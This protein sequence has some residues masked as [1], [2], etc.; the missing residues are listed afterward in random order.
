MNLFSL[1]AD[2]HSSSSLDS[3]KG[4]MEEEILD[5][6]LEFGEDSL[7]FVSVRSG[8]TPIGNYETKADEEDFEAQDSSSS[9]L[10][11]GSWETIENEMISNSSHRRSDNSSYVASSSRSSISIIQQVQQWHGID[12]TTLGDAMSN[13]A[14]SGNQELISLLPPK[15]IVVTT[16]P[17]QH[18]K[19][20]ALFCDCRLEPTKLSRS[21]DEDS[22]IPSS[23][24]TG[25]LLLDN[26]KQDPVSCN[27]TI[28]GKHWRLYIDNGGFD[29]YM[30]RSQQQ[31]RIEFDNGSTYVGGILN[32]QMQGLGKL[33][34]PN[35]SYYQ[36]S[37]SNGFCD[38]FGYVYEPPG[39]NQSG[40]VGGKDD[41]KTFVDG[42]FKETFWYKGEQ[43]RLSFI[44]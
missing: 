19:S 5:L 24:D 16:K 34:Y 36:G 32:G 29:G 40:H 2:V 42:S 33:T 38:G 18:Q 27:V 25:P 3:N 9:F 8:E 28:H 39:Q 7:S 17:K 26:T 21:G 30:N 20:I 14:I 41:Q 43:V 22:H 15:E 10:S 37:F 11:T 35:G 12:V 1:I 23:S 13:V 44:V 31:G 4:A 6:P